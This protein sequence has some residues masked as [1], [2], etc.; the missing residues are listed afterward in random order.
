MPLTDSQIKSA[1]TERKTL[2]TDGG[3]LY[4][5]VRRTQN[6]HCGKYFIGRT[7][8]PATAKGSKVDVHIGT[9]GKGVGELSL[10]QAREEWQELKL[11]GKETGRD[12][13][14]K[15]RDELLKL[16]VQVAVPTLAEYAETYLQVLAERRLKTET[17]KDY[18]NILQNIVLPELGGHT[19]ISDYSF[20]QSRRRVLRV[21]EAVERRGSE[22]HAQRVLMV[23]RQMFR[24][25]ISD[26]L[27]D[28]E[29]PAISSPRLQKPKAQH[30]PH[31]TREELKTFLSDLQNAEGQISMVTVCGIKWTL[32]NL[33][34]VSA[35]V[36]LRWDQVDYANKLWVIPGSQTGVKRTWRHEDIDHVVPLTPQMEMMLN[37]LQEINGLRD[38]AFYSVRG[39]KHPHL[40][41]YSL[42]KTLT[43][44]GYKGRLDVHGMRRTAGT[45]LC[46]AGWD[47]QIVSRQLGHLKPEDCG[48]EA[49]LRA[50]YNA[51]DPLDMNERR[52]LLTEWNEML[53]ELGMVI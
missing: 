47:W 37:R 11:W 28:G 43:D 8:F 45:A 34:R 46:G 13:R 38:H 44:L 14:D 53:V 50:A 32:L 39:T 24:L 17:I 25:A 31:L 35:S 20:M 52:Q 48:L 5:E 49:K 7:R 16:K 36:S 12:L 4:L 19:R 9:Y 51:N 22:S 27:I 30:H 21:A 15:K 26:A 1:T 29:N 42:N 18:R 6:G 2:L 40:N 41:P 33:L 23:M 10:K 3:G